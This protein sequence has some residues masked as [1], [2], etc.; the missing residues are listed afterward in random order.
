MRYYFKRSGFNRPSMINVLYDF[1]GV[2]RTF[3]ETGIWNDTQG[4]G[5]FELLFIDSY[6]GLPE[7]DKE[8]PNSIYSDYFRLVAL[9]N[10]SNCFNNIFEIKRWEF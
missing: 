1:G 8:L 5:K 7:I 2:L 6:T 4:G 9:E 3:S 10:L